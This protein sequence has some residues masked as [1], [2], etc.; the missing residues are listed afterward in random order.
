MTAITR[1]ALSL[2]LGVLSGAAHADAYPN[3]TEGFHGYLR[4]ST[5]S[6]SRH[7]PQSC[8]ALGGPT[9]SYRLGNECDSYTEFGYTKELATAPNGVSFVGTIWVSGYAPGSD[10]R[11]AGLKLLKGYVEARGLPFLNGGMAWIGKRYYYRPDI[12]MLDMQYINMNGTG[13]GLDKIG[14][15]P[16]KLSYAVFKDNDTNTTGAGGAIVNTPAALRQNL[17]YQDLPVNAGGTLDAALT[18]VTASGRNRAKQGQGDAGHD[19]WAIGLFHRQQALGGSNLAGFQYG[20]GPGTGIGLCCSR[21][22]PSGSTALGADVKRIRVLDNLV[23]QPSR[24]FS[25]E[26]AALYQKDKADDPVLRNT[27]TTL[28]V[29]PVYAALPNLKLQAELGYTALRQDSTGQTARLTKLTLAP[30]IAL[31]ES[32]WSRP[33]LR[34]FVT[35]GKWNG[36]AT[37]LV[38]ASNN[39]GPV[40]GDATSGTSAGL[41]VEAWW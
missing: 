40:Y 9:S 8:Y 35:Y 15:G 7:G 27:W 3:D 12:H 38:N 13:G 32:Y 39:G 28:G 31:G 25:L 33:E 18:I 14:L 22:G 6:S 17:L 24:R 4:A 41:Q 37:P 34:L 29:R 16:G 20:S 19:G 21:M 36:A 10:F 1:M 30:A 23:I 2:A 11:D 26:L 5:G